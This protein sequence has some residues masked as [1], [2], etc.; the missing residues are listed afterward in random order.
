M[1]KW[2]QGESYTP[3]EIPVDN[4]EVIEQDTGERPENEPEGKGPLKRL[5]KNWKLVVLFVLGLV[6][7]GGLIAWQIYADHRK[8]ETP[9]STNTPGSLDWVE[10]ND[11]GNLDDFWSQFDPVFTYTTEELA[12][13]RAWG[14]TGSEIEQYQLDEV[15]ASELI[16]ASRLAQEEARATL[17]NPESAEYLALLNQTWLGEK[18]TQAPNFIVNQTQYSSTTVTLNADYDKVPVHG[19]NLFIK[20]TLADGTHHWMECSPFRYGSL[21]D[22]GNIVVT[23]DLI[24]FDGVQY[25]TNMR[26]KVVD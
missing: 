8:M 23:Y 16:E 10:P 14:Y 1:P 3:T 20:V 25:I 24:V 4:P 12:S 19:T 13:L 2:K 22:S 7:V 26:E 5:S 11:P 15:P 21:A 6:F 9:A 17:S 18:A